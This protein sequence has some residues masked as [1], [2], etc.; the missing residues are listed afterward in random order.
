MKKLLKTLAKSILIP[1]GLTAAGSTDEAVQ[2]EVYGSGMTD[3]LKLRNQRYPG[4][5]VEESEKNKKVDF[6]V[7][8]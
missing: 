5:F 4:K 7:S 6:F 3:K 1:L 8:Y 2:K